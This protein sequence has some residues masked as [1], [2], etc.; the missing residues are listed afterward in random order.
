MENL[1]VLAQFS[2]QNF[3][4]IL[5]IMIIIIIISSAVIR[6]RKYNKLI[7]AAEMSIIAQVGTSDRTNGRRQQV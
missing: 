3:H 4:S 7:S 6:V 2:R 5:I 1:S